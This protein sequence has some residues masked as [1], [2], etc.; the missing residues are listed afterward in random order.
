MTNA[1]TAVA[2][3]IAAATA[4]VQPVAAAATIT[5]PATTFRALPF[6][7]FVFFN[8]DCTVY[9]ARKRITPADLDLE[10]S[11]LPPTTLASLGSMHSADPK[12]LTR[13]ESFRGAMRNACLVYGV[14]CLGGFAVPFD[15]AAEVAA[16]LDELVDEFYSLK[17]TFLKDFEANREAWLTKKEFAQW[18]DKIRARLDTVTHVDKQ[19]QASWQAFTLGSLQDLPKGPG[20]QE[21]PLASGVVKAFLGVEDSAIKE[22]AVM[23]K[24]LLENSVYDSNGHPR[25][26]VTQKILSPIRKILEKAD[27][28]SFAAPRL[29]HVVDYGRAV[30]CQLPLKGKLVGAFKDMV[31]SLAHALTDPEG[32][33]RSAETASGSEIEISDEDSL[34]LQALNAPAQ[35]A[36]VDS[37]PVEDDLFDSSVVAS[38]VPAPAALVQQVA[39]AEVGEGEVVYDPF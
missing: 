15:K 12:Q 30:L 19:L 35:V 21:S 13:F 31:F 33:I 6:S 7:G 22:L 32:I 28:L 39:M 36:Q 9:T 26:E 17:A 10:E 25:P 11:E 38:S 3:A 23:A 5:T 2:L 34:A 18:T 14:R 1:V 37:A 27:A 20:E 8:V 16:K 29:R 24:S 4:P